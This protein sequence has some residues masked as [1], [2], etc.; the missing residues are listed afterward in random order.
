MALNVLNKREDFDEYKNITFTEKGYSIVENYLKE[1]IKWYN[2]KKDND[3]PFKQGIVLGLPLISSTQ[4]INSKEE[5][6]G[7]LK[8]LFMLLGKKEMELVLS[9]GTII[10]FK[11]GDINDS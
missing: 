1:L 4:Q 9:T 7:R 8:S 10:T 2:E 3:Y 6:L 11:I 5:L